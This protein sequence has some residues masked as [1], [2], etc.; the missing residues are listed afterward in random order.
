MKS[1][2]HLLEA[3][4]TP[5]LAMASSGGVLVLA[6]HFGPPWFAGVMAV[7]FVFFAR[8]L[9]RRAAHLLQRAT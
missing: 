8:S 3:I 2:D 6:C 7:L 5:L 4:H 9:C 1:S